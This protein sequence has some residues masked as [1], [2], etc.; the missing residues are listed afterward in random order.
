MS[1]IYPT[2]VKQKLVVNALLA[3]CPVMLWVAHSIAGVQYCRNATV[4]VM[5]VTFGTGL[6]FTAV[7]S[8][9]WMVDALVWSLSVAVSTCPPTTN[10]PT[11]INRAKC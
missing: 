8:C 1:T 9:L 11:L 2:S 4:C 7:Q 6:S 10:N 5:H 3:L